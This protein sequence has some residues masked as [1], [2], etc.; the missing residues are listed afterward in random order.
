MNILKST[1]FNKVVMA[2]TGVVLIGFMI[3]HSA[4]NLQLFLGKEAYN[5]YAYFLHHGL[6]PMIWVIRAVLV[7]SA[8]LH[9]YTSINLK[10]LNN[11]A[12]P[13]KYKVKTYLKSTFYSRNMIWTGIMV[14]CFII[15]HLLHYKTGIVSEEAKNME[16]FGMLGDQLRENVYHKVVTG[17]SNIWVSVFYLVSVTILGFH[18]THSIQSMFQ[19]L[20]LTFGKY[21]DKSPIF[22]KAIAVI[23][24]LSLYTCPLGVLLKIVQ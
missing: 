3:G 7:I 2:L 17:F 21:S 5:S 23:I 19:S 4:G 14:G 18:L 15:F 11:A 10:L 8:M 16:V 1:I 6:G 12:K 20:G 22:S 24:T 13:Q 9:V